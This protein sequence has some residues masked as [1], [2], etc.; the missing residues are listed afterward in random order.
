M[1]WNK[2]LHPL[3]TLLSGMVFAFRLVSSFCGMC[4]GL[5]E[6]SQRSETPSVP[7]CEQTFA[8]HPYTLWYSDVPWGALWFYVR[9][10]S[11]VP[12]H[13]VPVSAVRIRGARESV[14]IPQRGARERA[15]LSTDGVW[16]VAGCPPGRWPQF[17]WGSAEI[18][19]L[20]VL[21]AL[22][23]VQQLEWKVRKSQTDPTLW[24]KGHRSCRAMAEAQSSMSHRAEASVGLWWPLI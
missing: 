6:I 13:R 19:C 10:A 4:K 1:D 24:V 5:A 20:T 16:I 15:G 21:R 8:S 18:K 3:S 23:W 2:L 22:L 12:G 11:Q 7:H 9:L 17:F 14:G